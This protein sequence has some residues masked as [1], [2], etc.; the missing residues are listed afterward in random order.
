MSHRGMPI[1]RAVRETR[2]KL[3]LQRQAEYDKLT[4]DQKI[5]RLPGVPHAQRQRTRLLAM[6]EAQNK[7]KG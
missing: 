6:K 1:T 4:L 7:P 5:E 3:A 2:R